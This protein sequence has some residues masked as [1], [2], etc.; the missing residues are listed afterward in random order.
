[1]DYLY[2]VIRL[3]RSRRYLNRQVGYLRRLGL[4]PLPPHHYTRKYSWFRLLANSRAG[5]CLL[6]WLLPLTKKER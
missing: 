6:M 4:Y 3:T 2:N 5:L 1:M